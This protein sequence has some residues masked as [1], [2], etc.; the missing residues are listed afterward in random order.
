MTKTITFNFTNPSLTTPQTTGVSL[1]DREI[2]SPEAQKTIAEMN[3]LMGRLI[4]RLKETNDKQREYELLK[5]CSKFTVSI[6]L[7]PEEEKLTL[8]I[9]I[10]T[11]EK[12]WVIKQPLSQQTAAPL[13]LRSLVQ[14]HSTP[15]RLTPALAQAMSP[16][17]V[18][19]A[20][21]PEYR[22][23]ES[24]K[25]G[26][27]PSAPTPPRGLLSRIII[28]VLNFLGISKTL[29]AITEKKSLDPSCLFFI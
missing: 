2:K 5:N 6:D 26:E 7:P 1:N 25:T 8:K 13:N 17:V 28:W 24:K 18:I 12:I 4:A 16:P 19:H 9:E 23:I 3:S 11:E 10:A 14:I 29:P 21:V 20:D 15:P 22:K 27:K